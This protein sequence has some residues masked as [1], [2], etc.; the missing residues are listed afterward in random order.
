M[1]N[2]LVGNG[3]N[4]TL[5]GGIGYDTLI[6]G[7]GR[8][9]LD[10]G[11]DTQTDYFVFNSVAESSAAAPD[12]IVNFNEAYD[13]VQLNNIDANVTASYDQSFSFIGTAGFTGTAGQ[14]RYATTATDTY[15]YGDVDGDKV[16]DLMI[17]ISGVH[18]L[19][20]SDFYL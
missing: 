2:Q 9:T 15:V 4:N 19:T 5:S 3:N 11:L 17:Q 12:K 7:L 16:A 14:L 8:D 6:G 18:L 1:N 10:G 13:Y 20:S